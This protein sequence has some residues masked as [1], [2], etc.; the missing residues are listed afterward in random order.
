MGTATGHE[1]GASGWGGPIF[2]EQTPGFLDLGAFVN[3][4]ESTFFN[5]LGRTNWGK[6]V[7]L[8]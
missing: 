3:S 7:K 6:L 4:Q 8:R 5:P 1:A 2:L